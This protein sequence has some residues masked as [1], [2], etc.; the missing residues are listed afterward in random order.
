MQQ[1]AD[2]WEAAGFLGMSAAI[3]EEVYGHHHS[4]HQG[5]A[6]RHRET[7]TETFLGMKLGAGGS[8]SLLSAGAAGE[9]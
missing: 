8:R 3:L 7:Q 5:S 6:V 4:D 9:I 2:K 1:G